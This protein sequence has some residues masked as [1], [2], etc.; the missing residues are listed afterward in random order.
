MIVARILFWLA[1]WF[2]AL[3]LAGLRYSACEDHG[4]AFIPGCD[5]TVE[6]LGW[7]AAILGMIMLARSLMAVPLLKKWLA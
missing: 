6:Y 3:A 1:V 2:G 7:A 4:G 5:R